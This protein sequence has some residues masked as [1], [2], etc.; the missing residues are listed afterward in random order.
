MSGPEGAWKEIKQV[1]LSAARLSTTCSV[2]APGW[3]L[4]KGYANN[5]GSISPEIA[6]SCKNPF[7]K[8]KHMCYTSHVDLVQTVFAHHRRPVGSLSS[9]V[10]LFVE[11]TGPSRKAITRVV[12]A[13]VL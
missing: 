9:A 11:I 2:N 12:R 5:S 7:M 8:I 6:V 3:W 4:Q 10:L 1:Y 13:L